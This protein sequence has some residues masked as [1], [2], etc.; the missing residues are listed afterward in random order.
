MCTRLQPYVHRPHPHAAR[1]LCAPCVQALGV[2]TSAE[3]GGTALSFVMVG[4]VKTNAKPTAK[5]LD[6][7][8]N[9]ELKNDSTLLCNVHGTPLQKDD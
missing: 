3:G 1:P 9:E 5:K 6:A 8:S 4:I 7:R 2:S